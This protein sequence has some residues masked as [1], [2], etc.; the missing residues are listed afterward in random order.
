MGNGIRVRGAEN[1]VGS[2]QRPLDSVQRRYPGSRGSPSGVDQ[3]TVSGGTASI[4]P[5][6]SKPDGILEVG[7]P[8]QKYVSRYN[9]DEFARLQRSLSLG[10][11][12]SP[13]ESAIQ[14]ITRESSRHK[15]PVDQGL[16]IGVNRTEFSPERLLEIWS[17]GDRE[18]QHAEFPFPR[19]AVPPRVFDVEEVVKWNKDERLPSSR[20]FID[21]LFPASTETQCVDRHVLMPTQGHTCYGEN[22]CCHVNGTNVGVTPGPFGRVHRVVAHLYDPDYFQPS[23]SVQSYLKEGRSEPEV[24]ASKAPSSTMTPAAGH[25]RYN[26]PCACMGHES[27]KQQPGEDMDP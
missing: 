21:S 19:H 9:N 3:T 15:Y 27:L 8:R 23:F 26:C 1:D 6:G 20:N 12:Q 11:Q 7:G 16:S 13:V 18:F 10:H 22:V 24:L 4:L 2:S 14:S 5:I 25:E 17:I